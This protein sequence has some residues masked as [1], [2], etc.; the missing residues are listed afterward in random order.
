MTPV[1]ITSDMFDDDMAIRDS[2]ESG[3]VVGVE[4]FDELGG[5]KSIAG[6]ELRGFG[7]GAETVEAGVSTNIGGVVMG[8]LL[9]SEKTGCVYKSGSTGTLY[10]VGG[11]D[12][13]VALFGAT[14]GVVAES[15]E[16]ACTELLPQVE[17][18]C[19]HEGIAG[20]DGSA[21]TADH[22]FIGTSHNVQINPK[23]IQD[24][25]KRRLL[26]A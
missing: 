14:V 17:T 5:S 19:R 24:E 8:A 25:F 15:V 13:D 26:R 16:V 7:I 1:V 20:A 23:R 21:P 11:S 3:L 4:A 22:Q 18:P 6:V 2:G 10:E 12:N 9:T